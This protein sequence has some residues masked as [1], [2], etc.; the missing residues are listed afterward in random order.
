VIGDQVTVQGVLCFVE[1]DWPLLGGSF[2]TR[3]VE[4]MWPK[5]LYPLLQAGMRRTSGPSRMCI[6]G[7][8]Q[9]FRRPDHESARAKGAP[10]CRITRSEV[11]IGPRSRQE[12]MATAQ[13]GAHNVQVAPD[14]PARTLLGMEEVF[15]RDVP[16]RGAFLS[17]MF[18][19]FSEEI[20]RHWA[21]CDHSPYRDLGR[22]VLWDD[23]G[24]KYHVLDF[25]LERNSDGARFVTELKCEI[26]FE[27]YRYL[28]LTDALQLQHHMRNAAFQKLIRAAADPDAQRVTIG[29]QEVKVQGA[30]LVWGVVTDQGRTSVTEAYGFADVLSVDQMLEDLGRWQPEEWAEWVGLRR[31]WTDELFDWLR[32]PVQH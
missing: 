14:E 17:R 24:S 15:R 23:S 22:P 1:A 6:E 5:Q 19:F 10:E 26:E 7:W 30:V 4:V 31:Q 9:P 20:V 2:T 25:T 12:D 8:R 13:A 27:R 32:Y 29:G 16:R 11:H 3:G 28:T 21:R 18:A